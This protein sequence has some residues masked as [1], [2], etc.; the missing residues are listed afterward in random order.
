MAVIGPYDRASFAEYTPLSAQDILMPAM[1]M[2]Q[3]HE[4]LENQ[5]NSLN[6]ELQKVKFVADSDPNK[7]VSN[8]Y[9]NYYNSLNTASQDLMNQ[10]VNANTRSKALALR[11]AYQSQIAPINAGYQMKLQ[12]IN[13]YNAQKLKDP[14]FIGNNPSHRSVMDYINNGLQ[15]FGQQGISGAMVTKQAADMAEQISQK[16]QSGDPQTHAMLK[17]MFG[18]QYYQVINKYGMD[19]TSNDP[20]VQKYKNYIR[21]S[22]LSG[23]DLG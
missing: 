2:A 5:Y 7:E 3:Q 10:G 19:P 4:Q 22:V 1:V 15:P 6:D 18:P 9:N 12:E 11:S 23:Y 8:R 21:N 20:A 13:N 17:G 16:A 14:T